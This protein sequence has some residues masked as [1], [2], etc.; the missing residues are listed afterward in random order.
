MGLCEISPLSYPEIRILSQNW[1]EPAFISWI[2]QILLSEIVNV[3]V[4]L[5]TGA[6]PMKTD[7]SFYHPTMKWDYA[8][9]SYD[10]DALRTAD[11][12]PQANCIGSK[13][14]CAH[15][16]PELWSGQRQNW[17]DAEKEGLIEPVINNGRSAKY[18]WYIPKF[19]AEEDP[20]LISFYGIGG[21]H[22]RRK[23]A[24]RFKRPF[25]WKQY[26]EE[27]S[28]DNC[29]TPD[30]TAKRSPLDEK[31]ETRYFVEDV[32]IG[33]FNATEENDCDAHPT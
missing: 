28:P 22:N 6:D 14:P 24:E 11:K 8:D 10:Y 13:V 29:E 20:T 21:D 27:V 17:L 5:E 19:V 18:N 2:L 7:A 12:R 9:M 31:E 16:I 1:Q 33:Y 25:T 30:E 4:T 3:P 23:L 15:V 26:C 32:F